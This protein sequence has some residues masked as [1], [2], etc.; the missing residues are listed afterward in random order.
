[1][2]LG[3]FAIFGGLDYVALGLVD[4]LE[5][6]LYLEVTL[7]VDVFEALLHLEVILEACST[8]GGATFGDDFGGLFY[9]WRLIFAG[10]GLLYIWRLRLGCCARFGGLVYML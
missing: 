3:D 10:W 8:L 1:M 4:V 9:S 2:T 7:L 5:D 6:L